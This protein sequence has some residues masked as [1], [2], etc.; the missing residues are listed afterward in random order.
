MAFNV[1]NLMVKVGSLAVH[2]STQPNPVTSLFTDSDVISH[3]DSIKSLHLTG[4]KTHRGQEAVFVG[5]HYNYS[6]AWPPFSQQDSDLLPSIFM[7]ATIFMYSGITSN[8]ASPLKN[9]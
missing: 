3:L 9:K 2:M 6:H 7:I 1:R 8:F 5:H 4:L